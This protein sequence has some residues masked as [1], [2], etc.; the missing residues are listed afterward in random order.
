MTGASVGTGREALKAGRWEEARAAFDSVLGAGDD[1]GAR[2]GRAS[3]LW[4]LGDNRG[5][6]REAAQAYVLFR[7]AGDTAEAVRCAVWLSQVY[8]GDFAN[9]PAANGW[10]G[11]A[12]TLLQG[13]REGPLHGWVHLVRAG[14]LPDLPLAEELTQDALRLARAGGDVDLELSALAQLGRIRIGQGDT[15]GFTLLDEA[16]AAALAGERTTLDTVAN[17]GCDMLTAC[18][19]AH[20]LERAEQWCRVVDGFIEQFGCPYLYAECRI[21]YGSILCAKGRWVEAEEQLTTGLRVT[22]EASPGLHSR[23]KARLAWLRVRQG[24]LDDAAALLAGPEPDATAEPETVLSRAALELARGAPG[25]AGRLLRGCH[26]HRLSGHPAHLAGALALLV[27]AALA[28]G[29]DGDATAAADQ[30]TALAGQ[31]GS[32]ELDAL[33]AEGRG[34]VA[35]AAGDVGPAVADLREALATWSRLGHPFEVARTHAT[36]G[37]TLLAA[38]D[39]SGVGHLRQAFQGFRQLR[40][41]QQTEHLAARLRA[42]GVPPPR[43]VP[44]PGTLSAR[45]EQV[46]RLVAAGLTNPEIATRLHL[47]HKTVSHHVSSVLAK[48]GLRNRAEVAA[49]AAAERRIGLPP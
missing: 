30:L 8:H 24:D 12:S 37:D 28:S 13:T 44:G 46:V 19:L 18:E 17:T 4:W 45:E 43:V 16:M 48:L 29:D 41:G 11:R 36:L 10:A 47:S 31:A 3:A 22:A 6:V 23:A 40:A 5:A 26:H 21:I 25:S 38:A 2:I 35:A 14:L 34:R 49:Q 42:H 7:R 15:G 33:A 9:H 27:E 1:P 39:P 32:T 20:D